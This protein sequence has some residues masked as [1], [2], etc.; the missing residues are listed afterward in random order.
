MT[1]LSLE[2]LGITRDELVERV[3]EKIS[4]DLL[5]DRTSDEDGREFTMHSRVRKDLLASVQTMIDAA[6]RKLGDELVAPRVDEMI[7]GFVLQRTNGYGEKRGEPVPF[8]EYL[9]HAAHAYM[10]EEV[11]SNGQTRAQS[12]AT[13]F[14]ANGNRITH[15]VDKHLHTHMEIALKQ[16]LQH[17]N[18]VIADGIT[19]AVQAS[20]KSLLANVKVG[21][22][23]GR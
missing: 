4:E 5:N 11:D 14:R 1:P 15:A 13:Y 17:A 22:T 3:V 8:A 7:R 16:T 19:I 23:V 18:S 6:V 10:T 9:T 12:G 21:A 2:S 20:L